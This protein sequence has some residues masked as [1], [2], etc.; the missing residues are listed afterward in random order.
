MSGPLIGITTATTTTEHGWLFLRAFNKNVEAIERAGGIPVL[1]PCTLGEDT[2]RNLYDRLDGILLPGGGDVDPN[3]YQAEAHPLTNYTDPIRDV[4][5]I[6]LARWARDDDKPLFGICRGQQ[7]VNVAFGGTLLQDIPDQCETDINHFPPLTEP[8][9]LIAHT[10]RPEQGSLLSRIAQQDELEVN[11]LHHQA[12]GR[13]GEG[14]KITA[15]APDGMIE[16]TELPDKRFF[17]TVQWHPEDLTARP[18]M[19]RLFDALVE[20]SNGRH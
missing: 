18:V 16:A 2:L 1:I 14:L 9:D 8:R 10:V 20:A 13:I 5:E 4:C 11:S 15:Y 19:Q 17:H 6:R 12:I 7:I 3:S